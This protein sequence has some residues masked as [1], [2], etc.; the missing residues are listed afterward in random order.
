MTRPRRR[1]LA[2]ATPPV[3]QGPVAA[4]WKLIPAF[5]LR[6]GKA[7]A[8]L[9][10]PTGSSLY[11]T[12][13][14]TGPLRRNG[15]SVTLWNTDNYAYEKDGGRRL[16]QSHPW[17]LGVRPDGTAFG[18]IFDTTWKAELC[19]GDDRITLDSEGAPF[20]VAVV[21]RESPQAV[22]RALAELTG[23]MPLPPRWALGFH[24]CRYSYYPDARVREIADEFRQR[25]LPC[26]VIWLDI[27]YMEGYRIFTFDKQRFPDPKATNDYLHAK[28]FHSVWMIDPGVKAEPGY[29][30]YDSGSAQHL[31][32][33]T[34]KRPGFP[35]QGLAGDVR[36]PGFHHARDAPV[37]G[38]SL[39]G[40]SR[41]RRGRRLERHER[42]RRVRRP[43]QHHAQGQRPARR[44]RP[45]VRPAPDVS[46][47]VRHAHD[48]LD[49]RGRPQGSAREAALRADAFQ[50]PRRP[51]LRRHLDGR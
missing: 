10:V 32:V 29:A 43:G 12:G 31:W 16:Y 22:V 33:Q 3:S 25:N 1:R 2:F 5:T 4:D 7:G 44:R 20:R 11:G 27:H 24:Q 40:L 36:V 15:R 9:A 45:A 28:Q 8:S 41:P 35:R 37:V 38:R 13:E 26:D 19:T 49:A 42:T 50:L 39:Q 21:D 46:Q 23:T 51:A 48:P 34:K 18:V 30:V 17:V 6:D 14:V 47:H